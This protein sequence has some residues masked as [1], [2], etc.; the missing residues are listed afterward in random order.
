MRIVLFLAAFFCICTLQAQKANPSDFYYQIPE[1]PEKYT[2][3]NVTARMVDGLGFRY[4][5]ATPH[6]RFKALRSPHFG[7]QKHEDLEK[8]QFEQRSR[9]T[10]GRIWKD[11][12]RFASTWQQFEHGNRTGNQKNPQ[13]YL[14][15][16]N[17]RIFSIFY[18]FSNEF[19]KNLDDKW[20]N[21]A[22]GCALRAVSPRSEKGS[23]SKPQAILTH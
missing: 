9:N 4:Y 20:K 16:T 23:D 5:W 12:R 14:N 13:S 7:I 18:N 8:C 22:T 2:S 3:E 17:F 21:S 10:S 19:L 11:N 15:N 1:Y 6:F